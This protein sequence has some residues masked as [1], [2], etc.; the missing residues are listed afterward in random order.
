VTIEDVREGV[1]SP[2]AAT[3][4]LAR[5]PDHGLTAAALEGEAYESLFKALC[6]KAALR[7]EGGRQ[8]F[9][10]FA[11]VSAL[12]GAVL[13]IE[14]V[15]RVAGEAPSFNLWK[16]SPWLPFIPKLR[17]QIQPALHV[18]SAVNR[19]S[20]RLH[21]N[22]GDC[23]RAQKQLECYSIPATLRTQSGRARN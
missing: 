12:A 23:D 4:I 10:P 18:Q 21:N 17:R 14:T 9:A 22:F 3:I 8:V 7:T 11:F 6:A 5:Y 2:T 16:V 13:A 15:R 1:I 19:G 20:A